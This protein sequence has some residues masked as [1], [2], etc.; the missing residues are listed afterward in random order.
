MNKEMVLDHW[1]KGPHHIW[2]DPETGYI[3]RMWQPW[4]GLS[5]WDP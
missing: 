3:V 1:V 2:K 5:V 4:N